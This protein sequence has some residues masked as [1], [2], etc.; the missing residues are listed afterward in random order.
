MAKG[1]TGSN[2]SESLPAITILIP[3]TATLLIYAP[4]PMVWH[5]YRLSIL[6]ACTPVFQ[7]HPDTSIYEYPTRITIIGKGTWG[8]SMGSLCNCRLQS[9][10]PCLYSLESCLP[11]SRIILVICSSSLRGVL[12]ML[13]PSSGILTLDSGQSSDCSVTKT[14]M[15]FGEVTF[16]GRLMW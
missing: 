9:G 16:R 2:Y 4:T 7:R 10:F 8:F 1:P 14:E 6:F 3:I 5:L 11:I 13:R 15:E 12:G